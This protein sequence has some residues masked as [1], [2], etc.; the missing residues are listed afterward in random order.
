MQN[1][2][3]LRPTGIAPLKGAQTHRP[4]HVRR[5]RE[6]QL[7]EVHAPA[8]RLSGSVFRFQAPARVAPTPTPSTPLRPPP[9]PHPVHPAPP[10]PPPPRPHPAPPRPAP[11]GP[12]APRLLQWA[13]SL[14]SS[15]SLCPLHRSF[16]GTQRPLAHRKLSP[17]PQSAGREGRETR[18]EAALFL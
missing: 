6:G 16:P 15:Q 9:R 5:R 12:H 7:P 11:T 4:F 3:P 13:S 2:F 10:P 1:T 17:P 14:Q 18:S 8:R